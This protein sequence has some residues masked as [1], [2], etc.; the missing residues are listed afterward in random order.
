MS[1][2]ISPSLFDSIFAFQ[3]FSGGPRAYEIAQIGEFGGL[4]QYER[5][6]G[7]TSCLVLN[8]GNIS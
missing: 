6:N 5:R 2:F 8:N 4:Y 1:Q 7:L 3:S